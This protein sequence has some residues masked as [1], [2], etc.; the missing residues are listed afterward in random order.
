MLGLVV[1]GRCECGGSGSAKHSFIT[2]DFH[3]SEPRLVSTLAASQQQPHTYESHVSGL[4]NVSGRANVAGIGSQEGSIRSMS[5]ELPLQRHK[6][7]LCNLQHSTQLF[8]D[9]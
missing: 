7:H 5:K 8:A 6:S 3:S 4:G 2:S 9:M 1:A